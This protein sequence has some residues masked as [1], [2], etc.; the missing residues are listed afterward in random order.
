[1][2]K[3]NRLRLEEVRRAFRLVGECRELGSHPGQWCPHMFVGL[4]RLVGARAGNGGEVR[5]V[6]PQGPVEGAAYFDA[7]LEP[8]EHDLYVEFLRTH[9]IDRHPLA[10]GLAGWR[11]AGPQPGRVIARTRRQLVPDREW[12]GSVCY[13]EYHR[14]IRIDHCLG[15]ALELTAHGAFSC[16]ILHRTVGEPDFSERQRRLL[17]LFH[18]ELGRLIGTALASATGPDP[19]GALAPRLRQTLDCLLEGDGEKQVAARLGLSRTTVH[20]YVTMLY[21]RF[22]VGSRAE[23]LARFICRPARPSARDTTANGPV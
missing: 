21:R 16:V 18:D 17:H 10:I 7:G 2:S 15:S 1:M 12:Y 19:V 23:L 13:N 11:T 9:G 5:L 14:L 20:Q 22:D 3:S 6:R 4:S 8:A